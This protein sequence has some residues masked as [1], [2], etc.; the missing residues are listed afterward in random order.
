MS[1]VM[2][3]VFMAGDRK[4]HHRTGASPIQGDLG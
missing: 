4:M 1:E 2:K 3:V